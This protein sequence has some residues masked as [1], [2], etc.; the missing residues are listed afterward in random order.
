MIKLISTAFNQF[1]HGS[2]YL[3]II[4]DTID[5]FF[6]WLHFNH[7]PWWPLG[8]LFSHSWHKTLL[9]IV[10]FCEGPNQKS[11]GFA[12]EKKKT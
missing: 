5:Q 6:F 12:K 7:N 4:L 1:I 11:E 8:I 2:N 9:H 3:C 10:P